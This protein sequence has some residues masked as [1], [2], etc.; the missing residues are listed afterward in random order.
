MLIGKRLKWPS[1][2]VVMATLAFMLLVQAG[3]ASASNSVPTPVIY[4]ASGNYDIP[5]IVT[6]GGFPSWD[7]AYYTTDGSDPETSNTRTL[8]TEA[9]TVSQ[10]ETVEAAVYDPVA[11][12]G[13]VALSAIHIGD[14]SLAQAPSISPDGGAFTTPQSVTIGDIP[15]GDTA[16]Y[17]TD[18]TILEYGAGDAYTGAF[19]VSQSEMIA[20]VNYSP[21]AGW[22]SVTSATFYINGSSLVQA[23]TISPD[24]GTFTTPQSVTIGDIPSEDLCYYTTDGSNPETSS[25][26]MIYSGPFTVWSGTVKA[27]NDDP[28]LGWSSVTSATFTISG[29]SPPL[30]PVIN[31]NG[32]TFTTPQSVSITGIPSGEIA[33]YTTDGSNPIGSTRI[34]YA[35]AFTVSQSAMVEAAN[36]S[37]SAAWSSVTSATFLISGSST[38]QAPAILPNGGLFTTAQS[39]TI[40]DIPNG[41]TCYYTTDGSNPETSNTRIAYANAFTVS[42][43]ETVQAA[44]QD[45]VTGWGSVTSANFTISS[46]PPQAPVISPDGGVFTTAQSVTIG[47]IPGADSAHYTTDGSNPTFSGTAVLYAGAFTVSQSET[48][49][50][51]IQDPVTGWG[52]VTSATFTINNSSTVNVPAFS[53]LLPGEITTVAG[54]GTWGYSGDGGPAT[55]AKLDSPD[56]VAVDAA[57]NLYIADT[58][59]NVIR[60][61]DPSGIITTVAGNGTEGYSGDGGPATGAELARPYGVAVDAAGNLYIADMMNNVIRKV[62]ANGVITTIAGNGYCKY[63]YPK[64][65]VGNSGGYSG[66][67]G[68][69]TKAELDAP[70]AVAVD[71]SGNL[72]IAD[73][74]NHRIRKVDTSGTITTVAGNG[75]GNALL[76]G[77]SGDGGPV[78]GA[79][80]AQPVGVAVD[81]AGNLYIA[82][83]NNNRIRKVDPSGIITTVAGGGTILGYSSNPE[84]ATSAEIAPFGM[85]MDAAG[86]LY[87]TDG[88]QCIR[89]MDTTTGAI[90]TVA[91]N[92]NNPGYSGD[93]GP[94]TGAELNSPTGVAVD[95]SG[96]IYIADQNNNRI[97]E[98]K[99]TVPVS[100]AP[101]PS[102]KAPTPAV[103]L[104]VGQNPISFTIGRNSYTAGGQSFA[105]D[106]PP[107]ISNGRALV[108]V[109]YL[110]DAL[111]AQ[112]G[113]D[114]NTQKVTITGGNTIVVLTIGSANLT[115]NGRESQMDVAPVI[116]NGRAYLPVRYVAKAFGC[117]VS[118]DTGT[119]TTTVSPPST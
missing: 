110:A 21:S 58:Q 117:N 24:G 63:P 26:A 88:F 104:T 80:L 15:S 116:V 40:G 50:A 70:E 53:T 71:A 29:S 47:G 81:A 83:L 93:G 55:S 76:G 54:G 95:A 22:S 86:N 30:A 94:A 52:S 10:S 42:Q 34:A 105:M 39:V 84:P 99:A 41:N 56:S 37:P 92:V 12:W 69:A 25:I 16:Y 64:Y 112:A 32:G 36:Y 20:V 51:A 61:V 90:T 102:V 77:Y 2:F 27:A 111:G 115:T 11:G 68:L 43:S 78:T 114:A 119:Q 8:Y 14:S 35:G 97:R 89:K 38:S 60:K 62:D 67:G 3:L 101:L 73:T 100:A 23:P 33:Y 57:G 28:R 72:Y 109:R 9:F 7:T 4:A 49:Q 1:P 17:T 6:I 87:I 5:P 59:N 113:W 45:P 108:P 79:E 18:G 46:S 48:V 106:A 65:L 74:Y 103:P 91:G 44:I 19:T 31:P 118:W 66:D 96:N 75:Q 98:V 107:F 85:A 82:D 13:S